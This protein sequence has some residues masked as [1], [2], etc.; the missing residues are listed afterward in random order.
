MLGKH[1]TREEQRQRKI[2]KNVR[3]E[4]KKKMA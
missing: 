3:E 4:A 2:K 1:I